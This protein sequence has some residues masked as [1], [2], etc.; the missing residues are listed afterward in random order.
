[1]CVCLLKFS[2]NLKESSASYIRTD[3]DGLARDVK[4]HFFSPGKAEIVHWS[5]LS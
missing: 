2:L 1:V 3:T 5:S 4:A